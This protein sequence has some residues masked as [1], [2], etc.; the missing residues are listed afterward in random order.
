[1]KTKNT[2]QNALACIV[3]GIIGTIVFLRISTR[4]L[5]EFIP[6]ALLIV[7]AAIYLLTTI[8]YIFIWQRKARHPE[9]NANA[10]LAFWQGIIRYCIALDLCMFGF[11]KIFHLQFVIPLG[12]LDNPFS[13]LSGENMV[14]A[15]FGWH[16][17]FTV[18]IAGLQILGSLLLLFARTR[19]LGTIVLLPVLF[20]ILLLDY[21]YNLGIVVNIYITLLTLATIYLLLLDYDRLVAFFFTVKSNLPGLGLKNN[22]IKNMIRFSVIYIPLLLMAMYKF[23]QYYPEIYGKYDVNSVTLNNKSQ[24]QNGCCDS[25]LTKIFIDKTDFV[26]EYGNY[27]NRLIGAYKYNPTAKQLTVIWHYPATMHN[28]LTA[29]ITAGSIAG[30]KILQ[31][32]M[33]QNLIIIRMIKA[34]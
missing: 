17:A 8:S 14:W 7:V 24:D 27:K 23:P 30:S 32:R 31:G 4:F 34:N 12:L 11:Q 15:F 21:F 22:R 19:L 29:R 33:G 9:F 20:N 16:Y 25:I 5:T 28:T 13:S 18:I 1:M 6:Y 3:A 2:F 10:T 26:M